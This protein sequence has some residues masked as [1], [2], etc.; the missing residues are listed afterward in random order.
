MANDSKEVILISDSDEAMDPD[1]WNQG[2]DRGHVKHETDIKTACREAVLK[3]FPDVCPDYLETL[4]IEKAYDHEALITAILDQFERG[5]PM[6]KR[7][8]VNL[9]RK[10]GSEDVGD[11][12]CD[13][14]KKYDNPDWRQKRK[15][16][17]YINIA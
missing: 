17:S 6:P 11:R 10:R 5:K 16:P 4:A 3:I 2:H 12:L 14:K 13:L 7:Q 1:D 9:K 15:H 8:R